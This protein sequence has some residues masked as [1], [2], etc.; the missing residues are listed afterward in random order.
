MPYFQVP[1]RQEVPAR[2]EVEVE[3]DS[4]EEACI[5]V[6]RDIEANGM[7]TIADEPEFT[8]SWDEAHGLAVADAKLPQRQDLSD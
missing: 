5:R 3:A 1:I 2:A 4:F 7:I 6:Q 8:A